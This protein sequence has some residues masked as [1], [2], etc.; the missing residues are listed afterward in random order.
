MKG[1]LLSKMLTFW[2]HWINAFAVFFYRPC[3]VH[4]S[5][6]WMSLLQEHNP[7]KMRSVKDYHVRK[8]FPLQLQGCSEGQWD[9]QVTFL[10][11]LMHAG[12]HC[13]RHNTA[14]TVNSE[15]QKVRRRPPWCFV[16]GNRVF[17]WI[18]KISSS[19]FHMWRNKLASFLSSYFKCK[20]KG[21]KENQNDISHGGET[22]NLLIH[23]TQICDNMPEKTPLRHVAVRWWDTS[24]QI[25]KMRC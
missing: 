10:P 9:S 13:A 3:H 24:L 1:L 11:L 21:S 20:S 12:S 25:T 23:S 2:I 16:K 18:Y 6:K 14:F 19:G 17:V 4:M 8:R 7:L 15:G 5:W 22:Q